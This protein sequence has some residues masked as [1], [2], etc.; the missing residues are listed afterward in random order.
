MSFIK[1]GWGKGFSVF[2]EGSL[3]LISSI[4]NKRQS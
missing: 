2:V 4:G 1:N 3:E